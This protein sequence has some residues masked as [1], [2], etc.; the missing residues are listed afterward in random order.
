MSCEIDDEPGILAGLLGVI[1][2]CNANILTIHQSIPISG[3]ADLSISLQ[4][5]DN[6]RDISDMISEISEFKGVRRVRIMGRE[7]AQ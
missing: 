1:S 2:R 4:I 7:K 5:R 6:T 3:V